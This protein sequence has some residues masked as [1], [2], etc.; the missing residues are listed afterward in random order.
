[1]VQVVDF[2][3]VEGLAIVEDLVIVGE[4][5]VVCKKF[6]CTIS[7]AQLTQELYRSRWLPA[8]IWPS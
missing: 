3:D 6:E 1:M 4:E 8:V 5:V 2:A 7:S